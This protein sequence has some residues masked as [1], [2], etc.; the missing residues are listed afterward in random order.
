MIILKTVK[1]SL[2]NT[3]HIYWIVDDNAIE[4]SS[5]VVAI[6]F[7]RNSFWF[8]INRIRLTLTFNVRPLVTQELI[9]T[10]S[11]NLEEEQNKLIYYH[12]Q[13]PT[14]L[15]NFEQSFISSSICCSYG[16]NMVKLIKSKMQHLSKSSEP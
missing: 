11:C 2:V 5:I 1:I 7:R 12:V 14:I 3:M 9:C 6:K 8:F 15:T 16:K 4:H 13:P 10:P